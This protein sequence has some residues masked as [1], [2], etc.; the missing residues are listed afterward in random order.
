MNVVDPHKGMTDDHK[1]KIFTDAQCSSCH[2]ARGKGLL[3]RDLYNADCAMCH[4]PKAEGAI[5][6]TLIGPYEDSSFTHHITEVASSGSKTHHSMPGFLT[7]AGGPL[8]KQEL[9]SILK[10]LADLSSKRRK[11]SH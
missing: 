10:Y 2:V 1:V 6:P 11:I 9:D 4:G 3:G 8:N 5:G 7:D